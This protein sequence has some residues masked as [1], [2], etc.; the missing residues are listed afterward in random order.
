MYGTFNRV[1]RVA[2]MAVF[3]FEPMKKKPVKLLFPQK[4][5][6]ESKSIIKFGAMCPI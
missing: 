1:Y 6:L 4:S 2:I 5:K 3:K